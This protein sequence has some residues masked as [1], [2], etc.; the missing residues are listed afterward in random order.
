MLPVFLTDFFTT[1]FEAT[2][3]AGFLEEDSAEGLVAVFFVSFL[4]AFFVGSFLELAFRLGFEPFPA[5]FGM[6]CSDLES[7]FLL[8]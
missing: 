1:F 3:F 6:L 8:P 4:A 5:D 7:P 2:F